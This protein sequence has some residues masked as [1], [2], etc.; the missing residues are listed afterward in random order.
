M[1]H[2]HPALPDRRPL[3]IAHRAGNS[4]ELAQEAIEHGADML[5]ADVWRFN[6]QLEVRHLKTMGR[7]PLLWDRWM[8]APGWKQRLRLNAL[9]ES[10]PVTARIMLDLKGEDPLLAPSITEV[11]RDIQPEREIIMC[12][13]FW[14]HLDRV[15]DD[16]TIHRI[17]SVGSE[18]ERATVWSRLEAMEHPAVS[19]H[20]NLMNP[21][22]A[23]RLDNLGVTTMSWGA[24]TKDEAR[25]LLDYG[26][27]GL[28]I[29]AGPLQDWLLS[30]H[31]EPG[32][33]DTSQLPEEQS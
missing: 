32:T 24:A 13:R 2:S 18:Q 19:I 31:H 4:I 10:T 22:T 29:S 16:P 12:S 23:K 30:Q 28:T 26:I 20:R 6:R 14:M 1:A 15:K 7:I 25:A 17:Y 3:V 9:L 11:I 21:A 8:L 27:D 33:I 5:E